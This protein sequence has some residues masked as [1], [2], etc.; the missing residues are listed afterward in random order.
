MYFG[1]KNASEF[2]DAK[3]ANNYKKM[4]PSERVTEW[5]YVAS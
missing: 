2:W 1:N 3:K 4:T 5:N